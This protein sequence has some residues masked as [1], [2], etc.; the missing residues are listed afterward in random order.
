LLAA[1]RY[2]VFLIT[3]AAAAGASAALRG[4][5]S[6]TDFPSL[7]VNLLVQNKQLEV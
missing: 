4:K 2:F 1:I 6:E 5:S 3:A 7:L